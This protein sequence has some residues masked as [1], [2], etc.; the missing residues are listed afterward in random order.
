MFNINYSTYRNLDEFLDGI[1]NEGTE[2]RFK[3]FRSQLNHRVDTQ[4]S[5]FTAEVEVPGVEPG[6][7][8]VKIEG[9]LLSVSTPRGNAYISVGQRVRSSDAEASLKNGILTVKIPTRGAEV[10]EIP[11]KTV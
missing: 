8:N 9:R 3:T 4:D 7:I 5:V 6:D 10:L 2:G 1:L 11:V